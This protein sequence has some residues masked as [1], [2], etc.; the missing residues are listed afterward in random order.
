MILVSAPSI[1][2]YGFGQRSLRNQ[3]HF[4]PSILGCLNRF[5]VG[6]KERADGLLDLPTIEQTPTAKIW[7]TDVVSNVGQILD[8]SFRKR[9]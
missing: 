6:S 9:M 1:G 5:R 8:R 7:L 2:T 4:H 3:C